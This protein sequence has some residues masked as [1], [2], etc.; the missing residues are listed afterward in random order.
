L[1]GIEGH[2]QD[3]RVG[4]PSLLSSHKKQ[5]LDNYPVKNSSKGAQESN[6]KALEMQKKEKTKE[7]CTK[8]VGITLSFCQ[9]SFCLTPFPS[10]KGPNPAANASISNFKYSQNQISP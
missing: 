6:L 10:H 4:D 5:Q 9:N 7:T 8:R 2:Q 1:A 3:A